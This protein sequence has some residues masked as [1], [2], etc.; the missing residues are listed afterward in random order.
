MVTG[1]L[2]RLQEILHGCRMFCTVR[3]DLAQL[4]EILQ[5][6]KKSYT[7]TGDLKL[8]ENN[9][10]FR[11]TDILP[12]NNYTDVNNGIA[13][14]VHCL[15]I[16]QRQMF[17]PSLLLTAT[18]SG[19]Q[20][21]KKQALELQFEDVRITRRFYQ[22]MDSILDA[23]PGE[24]LRLNRGTDANRLTDLSNIYVK[25]I[26]YERQATIWDA[27]TFKIQCALNGM[28]EQRG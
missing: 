16:L 5:G 10:M 24:L 22:R 17:G 19:P 8:N 15:I 13:K 14:H 20:R 9:I 11:D 21:D 18:P 7:V 3:G 12:D 4:Q 26:T 28:S 27:E 6:D 2:K 23:T 25:C 1:D